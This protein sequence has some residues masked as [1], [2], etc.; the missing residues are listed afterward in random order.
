MLIGLTKTKVKMMI[1][2][3]FSILP[4]VP[5][6]AMPVRHQQLDAPRHRS[7]DRDVGTLH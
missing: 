7:R 2:D 4:Y 1:N 3:M 6:S 5:Y